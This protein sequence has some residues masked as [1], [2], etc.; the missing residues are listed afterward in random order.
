MYSLHSQ[1]LKIRYGPALALIR[2]RY[3]HEKGSRD[4]VVKAKG[5]EVHGTPDEGRGS[6]SSM[7]GL[8][9]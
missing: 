2:L 7:L 4:R 1:K 5:P 6:R 9:L 8:E 3:G